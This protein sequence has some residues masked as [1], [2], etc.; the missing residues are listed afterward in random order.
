MGKSEGESFSL[1][2]ENIAAILAIIGKEEQNTKSPTAIVML[3]SLKD[4]L[5]L[6]FNKIHQ[7]KLDFCM[8]RM[9]NAIQQDDAYIEYGKIG[10]M[11]GLT[12]TAACASFMSTIQQHSGR[13]HI[14]LVLEEEGP[15][16][17][18]FVVKVNDY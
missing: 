8:V 2:K 10:K 7:R 14:D 1:T 17:Y 6:L 9:G 15:E 13:K 11:Q 3:G 18:E 4:N 5:Q 16:F 12:K